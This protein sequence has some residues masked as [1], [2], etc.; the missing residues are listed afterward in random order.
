MREQFI[1][2]CSDDASCILGEYLGVAT[3]LTTKYAFVK[4]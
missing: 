1:G 2:F 4:S 3:L